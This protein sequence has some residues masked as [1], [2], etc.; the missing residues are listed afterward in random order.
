MRN[1]LQKVTLVI[2]IG[3][4]IPGFLFAKTDEHSFQQ[5]MTSLHSSSVWPVV[6]TDVSSTRS[7]FGPRHQ[8]GRYDFHRGIDIAADEGTPVLSVLNAEVVKVKEF[9]GLGTT[10]I[11][12]STLGDSVL[13]HDYAVEELYLYYGHLSEASVES[14]T[15]SA[16]N[17]IGLSGQ[18]G[19]ATYPHLHLEMR[20]GVECSLEHQI[21]RPDKDC[22]AAQFD[23]HVHP[24]YLFTPEDDAERHLSLV[25]EPSALEGGVVS[26][27]STENDLVV[28]KITV[29]QFSGGEVVEKA[30]LNYSTREGF[31]ASST[32]A[33]DAQNQ[34]RPYI[35]PHSF[36]DADIF[37]FDLILPANGSYTTM[38]TWIVVTDI[39]NRHTWLRL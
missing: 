16:G 7:T 21:E 18:S 34:S 15:L 23:P 35:E 31:D 1:H 39:W 14:G 33:L 2:C 28:N 27:S 29:I 13:W 17:Q 6:G 32:D 26:F 19:S 20:I 22:A 9:D 4:L 10:V 11:T 3:L 24:L 25:I 38:S 8:S 36:G 5:E 12:R 37:Q 30:V